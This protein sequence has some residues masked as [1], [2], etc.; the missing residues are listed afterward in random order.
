MKPQTPYIL[1]DE[2]IM[3]RNIKL[4]ADRAKEL[5]CSMRPHIKTHKSVEIAKRQIV[6]GCKGI[7]VAKVG[8]AE[9]MADGGIEDIF[10]AYPIIGEQKIKRA[11]ALSRRIKRLILTVDSILGAVELSKAAVKDGITL[12][13]RMEVDTGLKRTGV[14]MDKAKEFTQKISKLQGIKLTGI[15]TFKG[16]TYNSM[17]TSDLRLAG[18]EEGEILVGIRNDINSLDYIEVSGGS[19]PTGLYTAEIEGVDEIRPGTYVFNDAMQI[20]AGCCS[21]EDCALRVVYTVVSVQENGRMIVDGGSKSISTD[22]VLNS[23]PYNFKGYGMC[24]EDKHVILSRLTEEHGMV[25]LE[26]GAKIYKVGDT[27]SFIPNHVCTTVNL[28]ND[29][30]LK[31]DGQYKV[32]KVDARGKLY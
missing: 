30:V 3:D 10:M 19:T 15:F 6:A 25:S 11:I 24:C 7:T 20:A 8:E 21:K 1:I 28:Y 26:D 2:S 5:D 13:V 27:T 16:A 22:A 29:V 18:R 32:L 9:I 12:E 4:M 23:P 14:A 31:K 17:P